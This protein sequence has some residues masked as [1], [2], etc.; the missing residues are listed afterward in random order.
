MNWILVKFASSSRNSTAIHYFQFPKNED[1]HRYS[2]VWTIQHNCQL[3]QQVQVTPQIG[4]WSGKSQ[5]PIISRFKGERRSKLKNTNSC[6]IITLKTRCICNYW[7][8]NRWN[9]TKIQTS[10]YLMIVFKIQRGSSHLGT[11]VALLKNS[12]L[13]AGLEGERPTYYMPIT[14]NEHLS[15]T[16]VSKSLLLRKLICCQI[17][18]FPWEFINAK[19]WVTEWG[20]KTVVIIHESWSSR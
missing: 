12:T 17:Q 10:S 9:T 2:R 1:R 14:G 8:F 3:S 11:T 16:R 13:P 19:T 4:Q 5:V 20:H 6:Q 18:L 15:E 7:N